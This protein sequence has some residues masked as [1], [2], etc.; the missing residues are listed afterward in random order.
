VCFGGKLD[1]RIWLSLQLCDVEER[2]RK[3]LVRRQESEP[4]IVDAWCFVLEI[5]IE[6]EEESEGL[7]QRTS[8]AVDGEGELLREED[9]RKAFAIGTEI[10]LHL[11][12]ANRDSTVGGARGGERVKSVEK[13]LATHDCKVEQTLLHFVFHIAESRC[14]RQCRSLSSTRS[15]VRGVRCRRRCSI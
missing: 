10:V 6:R 1:R 9:D 8:D 15:R 13:M 3:D 11:E 12:V 2:G 5:V 14:R 7:G 4:K